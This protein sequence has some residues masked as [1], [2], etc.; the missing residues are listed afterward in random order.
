MY[1]ID[2]GYG[3]FK[4]SKYFHTYGEAAEYCRMFKWSV[5]RI[6]AVH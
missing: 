6:K 2:Y 5:K 1:R 4:A 3:P